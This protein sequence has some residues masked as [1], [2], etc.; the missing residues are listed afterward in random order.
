MGA[1]PGLRL[2]EPPWPLRFRQS[3]SM[4]MS[5]SDWKDRDMLSAL[6]SDDMRPVGISESLEGDK[7]TGGDGVTGLSANGENLLVNCERLPR[8]KRFLSNAAT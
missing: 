1:K 8:F 2:S 7:S 4:Y 5:L 6:S 3:L